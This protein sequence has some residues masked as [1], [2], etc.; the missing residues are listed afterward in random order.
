MLDKTIEVE[1]NQ[2]QLYKAVGK[3]LSVE[4]WQN[5][6]YSGTVSLIRN[7]RVIDTE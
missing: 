1:K 7:S 2:A 4:Q 6:E 3:R 5:G